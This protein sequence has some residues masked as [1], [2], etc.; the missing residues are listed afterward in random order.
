MRSTHLEAV[1]VSVFCIRKVDGDELADD[2]LSLHDLCPA[3]WGIQHQR[4]HT[5]LMAL[6]KDETLARVACAPQ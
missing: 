5:Q 1:V 4:L 3:V 6:L 2:A